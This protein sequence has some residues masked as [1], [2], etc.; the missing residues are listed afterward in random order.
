MFYLCLFRFDI[1]NIPWYEA[2]LEA[3]TCASDLCKRGLVDAVLSED[4]DVL[5]YSCPIFLSKIETSQDTC[6]RVHHSDIL[7]SLDITDNQFLDLCIACGCDYNKNIP[8][9]GSQTAFKLL[10]EHKS[11]DGI[12]KNT[13]LDT[14]ILNYKRTRDIFIN[15]PR[16]DIKHVKY[17][18]SPNFEKLKKFMIKTGLTINFENLTKCFM[19]NNLIIVEEDNEDEVEE[20]ENEVEVK[21]DENE[22]KVEEDDKDKEENEVE[23]F[24]DSENE[25]IFEDE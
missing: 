21:E 20:D 3:E 19:H 4:T 22:V 15:Y 25:Y 12:E 17:C 1:L 5:A 23:D 13:K 10:K 11:L 24:S 7:N 9:V 14:S 2:P 16:A 8:K 6:V 18:G